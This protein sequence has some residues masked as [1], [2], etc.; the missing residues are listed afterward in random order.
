MKK[1]I[2]FC[3]TV[4]CS[5]GVF[6]QYY[7]NTY[8][9]AGFNPRGVNTD[10]EEPLGVVA[11]YTSLLAHTT[12]L[13]W[14]SVGTIP[15]AFDFNGSPVTSYKASNSG[16]VT[17]DV[18]ATTVPSF[19][20]AS[21]PNATIPDKSICIWGLAMTAGSTNDAIGSKTFGVAPYRQHWIDY[22]SFSSPTS[23]SGF[24]WTY[25][26]VVLEETTN[27]IYIVDKRT[28]TTPLSLTVGIQID[29]TTAI[30][31]PA[32]PNH[33]STISNAQ[34]VFVPSDNVYYA[35]HHGTKPSDDIELLSVTTTNVANTYTITGE[36]YNAA[37]DTLKN[38]NLTWTIDGVTLN[39]STINVSVPPETKS[40]FT[41]PIVWNAST[42]GYN[43]KVYSSLPNGNVDPDN[44]FDTL[45]TS[46]VINSGATVSRNPLLEEFTTA[47]CQFC[48]GGGLEVEATILATPST[49][50]VAEHA[51]FSTDAMTIPEAQTYCADFGS[52]AP[53]ASID[54]ILYPGESD[55]AISNSVNAWKNAAAT[56]AAAGAPVG[57]TL[58]GFY[59]T[60]TRQVDVNMISSFVD[61]AVGDIR[62]T[63]FVVE[64]HV[65]GTG[66][67]FNQ[68]NAYNTTAG[69]TYFGAG[70]PIIGYDHRH[71]LRDVYPSTD[72]WGDNTVIPSTPEL[73][74]PY[75]KNYTFTLNSEWKSEDVSLVAFVSYYD[76]DVAGRTVL[77][78]AQ[79]KLGTLV[80]LDQVKIDAAS[81][82]IYPNPTNSLTN[83]EINLKESTPMSLKIYDIAGKEL[84]SENYGVM[85]AG[86]QKLQF[87]VASLSNGIYYVS[88]QIGEEIATKKFSVSK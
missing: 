22:L 15:F 12:T 24:Q 72:A 1:I 70:D 40:L 7:V 63:L 87:D 56:Q 33:T 57:I 49:I 55:V 10:I 74:T 17:F 79:A 29:S 18:A 32:S 16:V 47:P 61:Y 35:F 60:L 66:S 48:P 26:G 51:C 52:G 19:T 64:D 69:H 81:L 30:Q 83:L 23:A 78:A 8:D 45:T 28:F 46:V 25:W 42:G 9:P 37:S 62:V 36:L 31:L 11:G 68:V 4:I 88:L 73:N 27:N 58:T 86:I 84:L 80:G 82:S 53:T 21:L 43:I 34:S 77:N 20:N 50:A 76:S 39:T 6:A 75:T 2:T 67:G 59:D 13:S 41:H 65:T 38:Y 14:S 5:V 71:V 44:H 85:A 54:R 3:T